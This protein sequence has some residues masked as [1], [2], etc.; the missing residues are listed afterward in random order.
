MKKLLKNDT[1]KKTAKVNERKTL[2]VSFLFLFQ[3][4]LKIGC[5]K[6]IYIIY[7]LLAMSNNFLFGYGSDSMQHSDENNKE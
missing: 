2:T 4:I 5:L 3:Q 1:I 7:I 6:H